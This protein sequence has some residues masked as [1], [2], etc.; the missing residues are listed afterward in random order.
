MSGYIPW[1]TQTT[2]VHSR[3]DRSGN[4]ISIKKIELEAKNF[5]PTRQTSGL[6]GFTHEFNQT[7]QEEIYQFYFMRPVI[8]R[9][10]YWTKDF[11]KRPK[12]H[13]NI[14]RKILATQI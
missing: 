2:K 13:V 10:Q 12:Y 4:P 6:D 14:V 11:K 9:F 8:L 5:L 7:F 3:R 1:N